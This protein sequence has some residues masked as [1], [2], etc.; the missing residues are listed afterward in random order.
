MLM[1]RN[2][3]P[4]F[5]RAAL[6]LIA[7]LSLCACSRAE[8]LTGTYVCVSVG[9][10]HDSHYIGE[11]GDTMEFRQDGTVYAPPTLAKYTVD[12]D[13]VTITN[14]FMGTTLVRRKDRRRHDNF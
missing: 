1:K 10:G 9:H 14:Q 7:V 5:N 4:T 13:K 2:T 3:S 11:R 6:F 12:K 8:A